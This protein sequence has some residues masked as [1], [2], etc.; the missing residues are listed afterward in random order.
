MKLTEKELA[1]ILAKSKASYD[2]QK[3]NLIIPVSIDG[4]RKEYTTPTCS[5]KKEEPTTNV[6][7]VVE[8]V[9]AYKK[10]H[11]PR[12]EDCYC[13]KDGNVVCTE[14]TDET[15][16]EMFE[17][18]EKPCVEKYLNEKKNM[19]ASEAQFYWNDCSADT[20]S[21]QETKKE[22]GVYYDPY[23]YE[24]LTKEEA[25]ARSKKYHIDIKPYKDDYGQDYY[26]QGKNFDV[27]ATEH[28]QKMSA[29]E[30]EE[31]KDLLESSK[32]ISEAIGDRRKGSASFDEWLRKR[33]F[34]LDGRDEK[35]ISDWKAYRERANKWIEE[36]KKFPAAIA[37]ALLL[38]EYPEE[39]KDARD[40]FQ[41]ITDRMHET[42]LKKNADYGS[43]FDD[44]FDEFGMTS[45]LLRMKDKYNRLKSI[46]EKGQIQVKDESVEDTLLD[47]A[48]YAILTVL[49]LRRDKE[50]SNK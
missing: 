33:D 16:K 43:S 27:T 8:D 3:S 49:R 48:N 17:K 24:K 36:H 46:T 25:E 42:Y 28:Y 7:D 50:D 39:L 9:L 20:I 40:E 10:A 30:K 22:E 35:L 6:A 47:L 11:K 21:K 18:Y 29:N 2:R 37:K 34:P 1:D 12:R 23:T 14:V 15:S 19:D 31:L 5:C 32:K 44:L 41:K 4:L 26:S 38:D 45:A 13:S